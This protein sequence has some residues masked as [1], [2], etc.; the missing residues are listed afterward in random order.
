VDSVF[1]V[2]S[3]FLALILPG[4]NSLKN[5]QLLEHHYQG[6]TPMRTLWF[7]FESD[8]LRLLFASGIFVVK[9]SPIWLLPLL[10]ANIIDVVVQHRPIAELW[11]NALVLVLLLFLNIPFHV[12]YM[13]E[14]NVALRRMETRLRSALSRQLQRLSI[15]YYTRASAGT[16]NQSCP[17]C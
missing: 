3:A 13:R 11:V 2:V 16:A 15:G 12:L 4:A 8:H 6:E 17:R 5:G 7:L 10:T 9:H 14:L 1:S